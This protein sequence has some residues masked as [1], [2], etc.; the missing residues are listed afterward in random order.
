MSKTILYKITLFDFFVE[1]AKKVNYVI[2]STL[3]FSFAFA[4]HNEF[5]KTLFMSLKLQY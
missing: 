2:L 4:V 3:I 1:F 5:L